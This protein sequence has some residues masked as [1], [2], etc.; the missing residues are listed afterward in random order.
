MVAGGRKVV[1]R[2][3]R[4][5]KEYTG[6]AKGG[7]GH[8]KRH[9]ESHAKAD[10]KS[11]SSSA[12]VQTQLSFNPDGTVR[13][14]T[15]DANVYGEG[16]CRLTASNDL[17]LGFGESDGFVE[18]IQTYHNPNYRPVSRQTTNRDIKKLYKTGKEK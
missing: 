5:K 3:K 2:C 6:E 12:A 11:V 15:Y 1:A 16:L 14:F 7:T 8:L 4:C 10:E 13:N 9:V 17:P 18:Y